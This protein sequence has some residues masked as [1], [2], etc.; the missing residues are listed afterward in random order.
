MTKNVL[1][2]NYLIIMNKHFKTILLVISLIILNFFLYSLD[3][4]YSKNCHNTIS[5]PFESNF[6]NNLLKNIN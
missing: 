2:N 3:Y 4:K 1:R 5:N 6:S